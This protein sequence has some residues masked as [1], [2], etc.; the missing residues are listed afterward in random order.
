MH[1]YTRTRTRTRTVVENEYQAFL[2]KKQLLQ[3]SYDDEQAEVNGLIREVENYTSL[4]DNVLAAEREAQE[5]LET[6]P[7]QISELETKL[8]KIR[9]TV[10]LFA[11]VRELWH[12]AVSN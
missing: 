11:E 4:L 5:M 12:A 3:N 9:D 6:V 1:T 7:Q 2:Y 8:S 10:K